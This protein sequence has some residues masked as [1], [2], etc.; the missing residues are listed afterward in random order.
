MQN[1][2]SL[3]EQFA[4]QLN[5]LKNGR[6]SGSNQNQ[7]KIRPSGQKGIRKNFGGFEAIK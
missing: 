5:K 7:E 4:I 6:D 2:N 3:T 1:S